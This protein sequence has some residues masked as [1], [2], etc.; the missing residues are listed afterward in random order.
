MAAENVRLL[1]FAKEAV[2]MDHRRDA[3]AIFSL[4]PD[5]KRSAREIAGAGARI[6]AKSDCRQLRGVFTQRL[7]YELV[8]SREPTAE[9]EVTFNLTPPGQSGHT[10]SNLKDVATDGAPVE[11]YECKRRA[12]SNR[13]GRSWPDSIQVRGTPIPV[14]KRLPVKGPGAWRAP[15]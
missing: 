3:D 8:R 7:A 1:K 5:L 14:A 6:P 2:L 11:V 12:A 10:V 13:S 9:V 15:R 4:N